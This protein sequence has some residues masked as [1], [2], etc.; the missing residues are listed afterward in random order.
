MA[1]DLISKPL[2]RRQTIFVVCLVVL[3]GALLWGV[4]KL[5]RP[6]NPSSAEVKSD[7]D[8]YLKKKSGARGFKIPVDVSLEQSNRVIQTR[9]TT[10]SNQWA[11]LSSNQ[12]AAS[13]QVKTQLNL[14]TSLQQEVRTAQREINQRKGSAISA[15]EET[16]SIEE[17]E[18][19]F[20]ELSKNLET[21]RE[22]LTTRQKEAALAQD[23][24]KESQVAMV[25]TRKEAAGIAQ[26]LNSLESFW[27]RAFQQKL[28]QGGSYAAIY[29]IIGE[30]LWVADQFLNQT[31]PELKRIGLNLAADASRQALKSAVDSY[32]AARIC[33][34]YLWPNLAVAEDGR[35]QSQ[36]DGILD[37]CDTAF[38]SAGETNNLIRNFKLVIKHNSQTGRADFARRRLSRLLEDTGQYAEAA[39]YLKEMTRDNQ[40]FD[41]KIAELEAKAGKARS[42]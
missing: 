40:R 28:E 15:A 23:Q 39:K 9:L 36:L 4:P 16:T 29:K 22:T 34:A 24:Y 37:A 12:L 13:R 20:Q 6:A 18:R 26:E 5:F 42:N 8:N 7:L 2:S 14:V 11:Q 27:R 41:R 10:V 3:G 19:K 31:N 25:N 30:E 17:L 21:G 33:E 32:P 1:H 38:Q 35:R